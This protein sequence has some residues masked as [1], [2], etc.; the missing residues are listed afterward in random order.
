MKFKRSTVAI[1]LGCALT[2]PALAQ[3]SELAV[4]KAKSE[5]TLTTT[6][7]TVLDAQTRARS[8]TF[9]DQLS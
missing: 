6:V 9:I 3:Q 2:L 5:E 4:T 1:S 8:R 7:E